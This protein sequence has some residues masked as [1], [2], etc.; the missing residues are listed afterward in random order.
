M[1]KTKGLT[2]YTGVALVLLSIV[3]FVAV[4]AVDAIG[5]EVGNAIGSVKKSAVSY[6]YS[7]PLYLWSVIGMLV[8]G[9]VLIG[10][11]TLMKGSE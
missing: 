9:L 7:N 5:G 11:S 8:L 1:K 2:K 4:Y 3:M 10:M 6:F